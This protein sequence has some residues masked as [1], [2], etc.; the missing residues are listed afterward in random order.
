MKDGETPE[1]I[2]S[3]LYGWSGYHWIILLVNNI[4]D[5]YFDWP[6]SGDD[7]VATIRKRYTTPD[8]DGLEYAYSTIHHYQDILGN[9]IDL[10]TFLSLPVAERSVVYIYDWEVAQ[11]E[12]KRHI[13][14]LDKSFVDQ[15]DS[16]LDA[17]MKRATI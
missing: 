5:P 11:N 6:L 8:R 3:K 1:I 4:I 7:L 16:E 17:L 2:A 9:V 12:T 10:T 14:L 15:I 13:Q